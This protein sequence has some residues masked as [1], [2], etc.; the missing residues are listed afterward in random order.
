MP[1]ARSQLVSLSHTSY[2][3]CVS[4]CVRQA[5]LCGFDKSSG[6]SFE[7]RRDWVEQR[8]LKLASVFSIDICAY[9]VMS[10][11]THL[12]LHINKDQALSWDIYEVLQRWHRLYKGTVLTRQFLSGEPLD[13]ASLSTVMD[14]A[15]VY[16]QR[17]YNLSWFMRNLN[18]HIARQANQEENRTGRFWEG[19]FKSQPLL[20]ETA[21]AT[22]MAYVDLN[23]IRSNMASTPEQSAYTSI[24]KRIDTLQNAVNSSLIQ[25]TTLFPF[26][27]G[28]CKQRPQG[29][30]FH[31]SDYLSLIDISGRI[32]RGDKRGS[33]SSN[34]ELMLK[35]LG[36]NEAMWTRLMTS[37]EQRFTGPI[38]CEKSL[39]RYQLNLG[40]ER[41]KGVGSARLYFQV[42]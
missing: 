21:L 31:L 28:E 10:N 23:P 29:L 22:C 1:T 15:E 33:I 37:L 20:D 30:P 2:Y 6:V 24:K 3:H 13:N 32:I 26:V 19:R 39:R 5:F 25:P 14:I 7:H 36:I 27:G 4:R 38:G 34:C 9:A 35:R 17:L 12:V 18:E 41:V 11:H 16:R 40:I 8:L 42:A